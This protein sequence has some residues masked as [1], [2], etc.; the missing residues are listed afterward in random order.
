MPDRVIEEH[1]T[2]ALAEFAAGG[3]AD[4][5]PEVRAR[6]KEVVLDGLGCCIFGSTL[7]WSRKALQVVKEMSAGGTG[8][9]VCSDAKLPSDHA[10]LVNGAYI[11]AFEL[12]DYHEVA[13][14]HEG[15][16]VIPA[17]LAAC[18]V[19]AAAGEGVPGATLLEAVIAGFEVAARVGTCVGGSRVLERGWHSGAIFGTF[20][21]AAAAG[22]LLEL[23]TTQMEDALGMAGTF[24]AGLMSAQFGSAVK[25]LHHGRSAQSG[26]LAAMLAK[27]DYTGIR[28]VLELR[29]GGFPGTFLGSYDD[30]DL[31]ILSKDLGRTWLINR[32][33]LKPYPCNGGIHGALDAIRTIAGRRP[34]DPAAI[35][36]ITI[37][38]SLA[39]LEHVGWLMEEATP[40][41]A[42][43]NLAYCVAL[44]LVTG[45]VTPRG[46]TDSALRDP[47]VRDLR[48]RVK[49]VRS[50][51]VESLGRE[52]RQAVEVRIDFADG[53]SEEEFLAQA[54]GTSARP[55]TQREVREKFGTL[56]AEVID[57]PRTEAIVGAVLG[58]EE[59]PD[60]GQLTRRLY[61]AV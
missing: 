47:A 11:Q 25:R 27:A 6:A 51:R 18:D 28:D 59:I 19:R 9:V 54:R 49:A 43:M 41:G 22:R 33:A 3:A 20:G 39:N 32:I 55:L 52:Y 57:P 24:S 7:P 29:Y 26:V 58:L 53:D 46:F 44:Q 40:T 30:V 14:I 31:T 35:R 21:A 38:C 5:G 50:P 15:A 36:E 61:G 37:G 4:A 42:Q 10:A 16:C 56:T 13:A 23:D 45:D 12:D 17:A 48:N 1:V 8:G 34:L 60:V 2:R